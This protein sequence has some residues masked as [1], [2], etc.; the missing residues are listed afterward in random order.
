MIT[1][2]DRLIFLRII[3]F[4]RDHIDVE[5]IAVDWNVS[6]LLF[7]WRWKYKLDLVHSNG[8]TGLLNIC[9]RQIVILMTHLCVYDVLFKC[10]NLNVFEEIH[11]VTYLSI[12]SEPKVNK[13]ISEW[14]YYLLWANNWNCVRF[15]LF[16]L[17][18]TQT[19]TWLSSSLSCKHR[20]IENPEW[21]YSTIIRCLRWSVCLCDHTQENRFSSTASYSV[22][23][24][25]QYAVSHTAGVYPHDLERFTDI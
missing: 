21:T 2:L 12:Y 13:S 25:W 16:I 19:K 20:K 9:Q 1:N 24:C 7:Y 5:S 14:L 17:P 23:H 15:Q 11:L 18:S 6:L 10:E 3:Q 8:T 4:Y 22:L